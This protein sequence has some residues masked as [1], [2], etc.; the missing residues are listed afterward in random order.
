MTL[1][2]KTRATRS[3]EGL[4]RWRFTIADTSARHDRGRKARL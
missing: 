1:A 4:L 2:L 3:A